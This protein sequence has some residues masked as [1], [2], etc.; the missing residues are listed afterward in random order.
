MSEDVVRFHVAEL[1]TAIAFLHEKK[2][3][4]RFVP[5]PSVPIL[6]DFYHS[7]T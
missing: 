4:H 1:S 2:I 7:E 6:I 5:L 3:I